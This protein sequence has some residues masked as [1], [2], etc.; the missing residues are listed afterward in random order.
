MWVSV[1]L[2]VNCVAVCSCCCWWWADVFKR[3]ITFSANGISKKSYESRGDTCSDRF[4]SA[5]CCLGGKAMFVVH[6]G[7]ARDRRMAQ[8]TVGCHCNWLSSCQQQTDDVTYPLK[9]LMI[10]KFFLIL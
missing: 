4:F 3:C 9:T 10:S 6:V 2:L 7:W 8:T 1:C 5:D